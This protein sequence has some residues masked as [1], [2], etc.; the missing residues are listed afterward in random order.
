M[1]DDNSKLKFSKNPENNWLE[2]R[3][4]ESRGYTLKCITVDKNGNSFYPNNVDNLSI[5]KR[6]GF[7]SNIKKY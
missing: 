5:V 6:Q 2:K 3:M 1:K 4:K 7:I